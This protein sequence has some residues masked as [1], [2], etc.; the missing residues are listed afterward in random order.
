MAL[1]I[2]QLADRVRTLRERIEAEAVNG[3]VKALTAVLR[4]AERRLAQEL[5]LFRGLTTNNGHLVKSV[6]NIEHAGR[7]VERAEKAIQRELVKPG[8]EWTNGMVA[9][10]QTAGEQLAR[11]NLTVPWI[12]QE[13]V[14][15][16]F[17]HLPRDV[18]AVL[19]VGKESGYTILNTVGADVQDWFR[20]TLLDAIVEE[21]PVQGAGSLAERIASAGRIRPITIRTKTGG[22][23]TRSVATRANA[24]ARV[25]CAKVM[26]G[27]HQTLADAAL[28]DETVYLNI[29]PLDDRTTDICLQASRQPPMTMAAWSKSR[30]GRPPR[31]SPFHLCRSVLL[32]GRP[33]WFADEVP[34]QRKQVAAEKRRRAK[35]EQA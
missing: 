12:S 31:L 19:R 16:V 29:N 9:A 21:L 20:N 25:E 8:Y 6:A 13:A 24:I 14:D 1:T 28:G 32:G 26:N 33:E 34:E 23:I 5:T 15:A 4:R 11:A 7:V 2:T 3:Q 10:M 35:K 22:T 18:G 17:A 30:W 27:V